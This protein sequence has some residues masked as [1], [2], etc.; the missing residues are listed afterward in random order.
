MA[1]LKHLILLFALF[2]ACNIAMAQTENEDF[3]QETDTIIYPYFPEEYGGV[4]AWI[5]NH[6]IYPKYSQKKKIEGRVL[7]SFVVEA[8]GD[9][10]EVKVLQSVHPSLDLEAVR[11]VSSM[12]NWH[13]ATIA[14]EP[15]RCKY[16]L[17][18]K[19]EL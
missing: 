19:F 4:M 18:I 1:K 9:I 8:D 17:P 11:V 5:Q 3:A 10:K 13:P 7:V 14:G 16:T 12:P 6:L 2:F 15:V